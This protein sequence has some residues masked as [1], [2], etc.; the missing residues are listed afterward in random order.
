M[1]KFDRPKKITDIIKENIPLFIVLSIIFVMTPTGA[2]AQLEAVASVMDTVYAA[3]RVFAI[4]AAACALVYAGITFFKGNLNVALIG[5]ILIGCL[6]AG[7]AKELADM[8][9]GA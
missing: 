6:V 3:L 8:F 7:N 2:F 9:F 5:A 4:A 1:I